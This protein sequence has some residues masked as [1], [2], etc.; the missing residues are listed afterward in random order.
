MRT[1]VIYSF[2]NSLEIYQQGGNIKTTRRVLGVPIRHG[3]MLRGHFA[4]F[5]KDSSFQTQSGG[6]HVMHYTIYTEDRRGYRLT[7]GE[8]LKGSSQADAAIRMIAREFGLSEHG[9]GPRKERDY[10]DGNLLAPG[11]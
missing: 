1:G 11:A 2:L 3:E 5:S 10:D 4:K 9:P 8:G 7:V 6:K